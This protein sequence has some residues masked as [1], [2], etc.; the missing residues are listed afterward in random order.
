MTSKYLGVWLALLAG[1]QF[2]ASS[3]SLAELIPAKAAAW[4]V[5]TVG[6]AQ[7][8][9]AVYTGKAATLPADSKRPGVLDR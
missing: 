5:L 9:T 3:A 6:A 1:C 7:V 2:A 4:F 8:A